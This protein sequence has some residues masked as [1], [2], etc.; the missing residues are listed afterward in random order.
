MRQA[1]AALGATVALTLAG[2]GGSGIVSRGPTNMVWLQS[3]IALTPPDKDDGLYERWRDVASFPYS[4]SFPTEFSYDVTP[5]VTAAFESP[6]PRLIITLQGTSLKPNFA[7]QLKLEGLPKVDGTANQILGSLGRR[8]RNL[9][10]LILGY[11]VTDR[12]GNITKCVTS[13]QWEDDPDRPGPTAMLVDSSYH[14]LWR[15]D[16]RPPEPED[17]PVINHTVIRTS[18]GYDTAETGPTVGVYGEWE[19]TRDLPGDLVLP[20]GDYTCLLRL[21]EETFH[22]LEPGWSSMWDGW[23]SVLDAQISFTI[24]SGG[25]GGG[26]GHDIAITGI[27]VSPATP[28]VGQPATV[29]VTVANEGEAE[30]TTTVSLT[31]TLTAEIVPSSQPI[32][33]PL[34]GS[35]SVDFTWTPGKPGVHVLRATADPVPD[36]TDTADNVA[37]RKVKLR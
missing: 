33:V 34:G 23:K 24:D 6:A 37:S 4:T 31:D 29:T 13:Q 9:G 11:F 14:V 16:D 36:E 26:A 21:S 27:G 20:D 7:Y 32:T 30:E 1:I 18:Y 25:G 15:P 35:A 28:P 2:C 19:P 10:Y 12:S 5:A 3:S 22:E 17:G 8:Y